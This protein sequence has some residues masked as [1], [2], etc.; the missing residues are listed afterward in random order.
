MSHLATSSPSVSDPLSPVDLAYEQL[1]AAPLIRKVLADIKAD[2]AR[3]L[4]ELRTITEIPAPPFK[5]DVRATYFLARLKELGLTD[6]HID[7]EGNAIGVRK[8]NG[9]GPRLVVSGHL[10]TVFPEGTDVRVKER[11][12][13][14]YAPGIADNTRG[15]AMLLS[16]LKVLNENNVHTVGDLIFVGNVGEEG[17]GDLRGIKAL[18]RDHQDIDGMIG[19]EPPAQAPGQPDEITTAG[20]GSHRYRFHFK[21]PGGHSF[22]AYGLPSAIHAMG[23]AIAKIAEIRP[24]ADPKTSCSVGIISGGTSVNTIAANA[25]M[26]VDIRSN[27]MNALIETE[28]QILDAIR[29]AV[30]EENSRWNSDKIS[31]ETHLIGDRPAGST[32]TDSTIVQAFVRAITGYGRPAPTFAAHSADANVPMSL[33][34]PAITISNGGMSGEQ[35]SLNEW[36]D[37]KNAWQD[38]Q[39]GLLGVLSLVGVDGVSEPLLER[40]K[41]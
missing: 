30:I 31:V 16:W 15:L 29:Q 33:G 14:L 20:T 10:D 9:N 24:P 26:D 23:R 22:E 32:P 18:F 13:L 12:G 37:P 28:T 11:D 3:T 39:I 8:G 40:R 6:A 1:S 21:G 5:E 36:F 34:I 27:G 38:A 17:A 25:L 19:T 41:R 35:H 2:D 7:Q 4:V